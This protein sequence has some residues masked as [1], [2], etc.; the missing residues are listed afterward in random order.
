MGFSVPTISSV[1]FAASGHA[2]DTGFVL[3]PNSHDDSLSTAE[4]R[5]PFEG[6]KEIKV[7]LLLGG[8]GKLASH[9]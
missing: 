7:M 9:S 5:L 6:E 8:K 4:Y 3:N 2:G 1:Q